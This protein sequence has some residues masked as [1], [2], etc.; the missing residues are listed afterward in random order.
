[1]TPSE[2]LAAF[3]AGKCAAAWQAVSINIQQQYQ[4]HVQQTLAAT[5][6]DRFPTVSKPEPMAS[7]VSS[8]LPVS[9]AA[10]VATGW[11]LSDS[12]KTVAQRRSCST[13]LVDGHPKSLSSLQPDRKTRWVRWP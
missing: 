13:V 7:L 12:G 10:G 8:C 1:M 11:R 9:S 3:R 4:R 5:A 6:A 2:P